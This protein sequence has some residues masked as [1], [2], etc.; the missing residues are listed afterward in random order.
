M[1]DA[2][3]FEFGVFTFVGITADQGTAATVVWW[4]S[5]AA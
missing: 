1:S 4:R 5:Q 2:R 3:R